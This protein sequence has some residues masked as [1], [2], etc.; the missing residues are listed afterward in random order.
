MS[1][2][3][4]NADDH[5]GRD[6]VAELGREAFV[7]YSRDMAADN[8]ADVRLLSFTMTRQGQ[9]LQIHT[10]LGQVSAQTELMG[11]FNIDNVLACVASLFSMGLKLDDIQLAVAHLKA[12][13]GR[14]ESFCR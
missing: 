2:R 13:T 3:V 10:P 8:Q 6:L 7:L 1:T 12:I 14:M 4:I 9:D 11:D 5:F